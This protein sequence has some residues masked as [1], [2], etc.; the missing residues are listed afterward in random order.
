MIQLKPDQEHLRDS[1]FFSVFRDKIVFDTM[2]SAMAYRSDIIGHSGGMR[3]IPTIYCRSGEIIA[4]DGLQDP[5]QSLSS[6]LGTV[7]SS[8]RGPSFGQIPQGNRE[9]YRKIEEG[10]SG[11]LLA[12]YYLIFDCFFVFL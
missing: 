2:E 3:R 6:R 5:S 9:E 7:A 12:Y 1:V 10:S 8:S 11:F 4:A